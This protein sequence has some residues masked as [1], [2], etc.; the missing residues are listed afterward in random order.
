M[1]TLW[2]PCGAAPDS[3]LSPAN[4]L[5][6]SILKIPLANVLKPENGERG[7]LGLMAR[8]LTVSLGWLALQR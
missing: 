4:E 1:A 2:V 7:F 5:E 3:H 8:V 6:I